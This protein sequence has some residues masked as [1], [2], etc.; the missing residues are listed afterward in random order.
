MQYYIWYTEF[1]E[2]STMSF[3]SG[4]CSTPGSC[5]TFSCHVFWSLLDVNSSDSSLLWLWHFWKIQTCCS[6]EY[7][8]IWVYLIMWCFFMMRIL[9]CI[10]DRN[11]TEVVL[12]SSPCIISESAWC[13]LVLFLIMLISFDHLLNM[14]TGFST[15]KITVF[16]FVV[17]KYIL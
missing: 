15:S 1:T 14:L 10:F 6:P 4:S 16:P 3:F 5:L 8:L 2:I 13:L 7:P 11:V 12:Y 9:F 17:N